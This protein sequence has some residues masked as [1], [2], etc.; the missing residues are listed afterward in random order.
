M[1]IYRPKPWT[2]SIDQNGKS[3]YINKETGKIRRQFPVTTSYE[4]RFGRITAEQVNQPNVLLFSFI[5][6]H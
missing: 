2:K 5:S 6:S 3:Y 4:E 1:D